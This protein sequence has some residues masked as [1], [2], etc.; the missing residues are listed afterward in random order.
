MTYRGTVRDGVVVFEDNAA[1]LCDGTRVV[2]APEPADAGVGA[3]GSPQAVLTAGVKWAGDPR[4]LDEL[5]AEVQRMR[6]EDVEPADS[7]DRRPDRRDD[8]RRWLRL[9][10]F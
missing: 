8:P 5:L 1:P 6:D 3:A 2:V 10:H 4:E 7:A 9:A